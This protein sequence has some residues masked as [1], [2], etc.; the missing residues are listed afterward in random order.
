MCLYAREIKNPRYLPNKKN[1]GIPPIL[2]HQELRYIKID[3]GN[4]YE[5]RKKKYNNW[6][7]RL[8]EELKVQENGLFV[9]F[10]FS[11]DSLQKLTDEFQIKECNAI[12][13]I[14]VRRFLERWRKATKKSLRHFFV[15]ELGDNFTERLHI[16]G[17][18]FTDNEKLL[19]KTWKYGNIDIGYEC[20]ERT[21]NYISKYM[22]KVDTKHP[23]FRSIV[24]ASPGIGK[25]YIDSIEA[26]RNK[27]KGKD[28]CTTYHE[29]NGNETQL[30]RYYK[31]KLY[32]EKQ[33]EFLA[34]TQIRK[35]L[36]YVRGKEYNLYV[37][38]EY[39]LY[40]NWLQESQRWNIDMGYGK[41]E[42]PEEIRT[43]NITSRM[44]KKGYKGRDYALEKGELPYTEYSGLCDSSHVIFDNMWNHRDLSFA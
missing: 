30:P 36:I 34:L 40:Q 11:P 6:R 38:K 43:W 8:L 13:T 7:I 16:H 28:T 20:S 5:C 1:G 39:S 35:G 37:P 3:C 29:K 2:R 23:G 26:K 21:I 4:C 18:V 32:T 27:F 24:L 33:Q 31:K 25:T 9:T 19:E 42:K 12:A 15:T 14:A 44:L 22:L 10:S 41:W 17:I